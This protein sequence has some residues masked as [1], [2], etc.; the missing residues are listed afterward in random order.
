MTVS[1][2]E[3]M[4]AIHTV[5]PKDSR[6]LIAEFSLATGATHYIIRIQDSDGFYREDTVASSPAEIGSLTPYTEYMLS[7]MAVNSGGRSQPS[8]TITAKTGTAVFLT[9]LF[10]CSSLSTSG[11]RNFRN[12]VNN[13]RWVEV[14]CVFTKRHWA[15]LSSP[16]MPCRSHLICP[17]VP[18]TVLWERQ[19]IH[20]I[21]SS[22]FSVCANPGLSYLRNVSASLRAWKLSRSLLCH[23]THK[24][25][26]PQT[27]TWTSGEK[28]WSSCA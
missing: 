17:I 24:E 23:T 28:I 4:S 21:I 6:T 26:S 16:L 14:S 27:S 5:K 25:I 8:Q 7:I 1:A 15:L 10:C 13:P 12:R 20:A 3:E 2:P 19:H 18:Q 9:L 22:K 11:K